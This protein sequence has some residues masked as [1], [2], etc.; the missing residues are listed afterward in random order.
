MKL[1]NIFTPKQ[2]EDFKK[3]CEKAKFTT[4]YNEWIKADFS[5]NCKTSTLKTIFADW[6]VKRSVDEPEARLEK[7]FERLD[8]L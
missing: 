7:L 6:L 2:L 5:E 1:T 3:R 8:K 4:L